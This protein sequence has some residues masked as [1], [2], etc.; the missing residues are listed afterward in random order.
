MLKLRF[1]VKLTFQ[2]ILSCFKFIPFV[3]SSCFQILPPHLE[4][5][6]ILQM[7]AGQVS[8]LRSEV[9]ERHEEVSIKDKLRETEGLNIKETLQDQI[10]QC[11]IECR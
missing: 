6:S 2:F 10:G 11:F 8:V 7:R 5:A 1:T 9:Q 4:A 3:L